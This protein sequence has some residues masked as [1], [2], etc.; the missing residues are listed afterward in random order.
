MRDIA[1]QATGLLTAVLRP[2]QR[3]GQHYSQHAAAPIADATLLDPVP[4]APPRRYLCALARACLVV[5]TG[6]GNQHGQKKPRAVTSNTAG[7]GQLRQPDSA[8]WKII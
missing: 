6:K 5:A 1:T 8:A 3:A 4:S 7:V 2:V